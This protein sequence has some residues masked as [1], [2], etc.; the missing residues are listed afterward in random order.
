MLR[1]GGFYDYIWNISQYDCILACAG[2]DLLA[3]RSGHSRPDDNLVRRRLIALL[4]ALFDAPVALQVIIF[5]V[6]SICLLVFTRK[7][8]VEKL[9]TGSEKTNVDALIGTKGIV[10]QPIRP[11]AVGQVKVNGQVWSAV[12]KTPETDIEQGREVKV[13]AIEGVKLVVTPT[14]QD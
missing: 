8:F 10:V 4:T 3:H 6:V 9:K 5:F 14:R 1:K 12:G 13:H 7:I 2:T 11:F